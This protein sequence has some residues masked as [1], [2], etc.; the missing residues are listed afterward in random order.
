MRLNDLGIPIAM[1]VGKHDLLATEPDWEWTK[2][3]IGESLKF[4]KVYDYG[5]MTFL[6]G[7]DNS[8][9]HDILQLLH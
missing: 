5:H 6:C 1:M 9:V 2:K 8:Y 4:Y 7:K 3:Q